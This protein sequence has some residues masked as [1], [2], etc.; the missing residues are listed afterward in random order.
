LA[1][2][3]VDRLAR[4][5]RQ[6]VTPPAGSELVVVA[7]AALAVWTIGGLPAVAAAGPRSSHLVL[8][9]ATALVAGAITVVGALGTRTLRHRRLTWLG[10]AFLLYGAVGA[11]LTVLGPAT[12]HASPGLLAAYLTAL[13]VF[14]ALL[15]ATL[16]RGPVR[17]ATGWPWLGAG[18][19]AVLAAVVGAAAA[20]W[21]VLTDLLDSPAPTGG[22][23]LGLDV[24]AATTL[25]AGHRR[26]DR[27]T[28]RV[29]AGLGVLGA[30]RTFQ[31]L[32]GLDVADADLRL[33]GLRL[34]GV[35]VVLAGV[36]GRLGEDVLRVVSQRDEHQA[37]A[38]Q[39]AS[40]AD[41]RAAELAEVRRAV[42]RAAE[43]DHELANGLAG[44]SGVAYLLDQ[45]AGGML[46]AALRAELER[47]LGLLARPT[48]DRPGRGYD[49]ARAVA[50]LALLRRA[51]GMDI[52]VETD[53]DLRVD[54]DRDAL[55]QVLANLLTNCARHAPG[56][57]VT[58]VATR[59]DPYV[60]V[61]VRDQGPGIPEG[62]E[63]LVLSR[64]YSTGGSG[65]GL[66]VSARLLDRQGGHLR[67]L[68][69]PPGR[70]GFA[71]RLEL[72][73]AR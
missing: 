66:D 33:A 36:A 67:I 69:R 51:T 60:V 58:I 15:L 50:E 47:L 35:V 59:R 32:A 57:P 29:G 34:L 6:F 18:A 19:G 49:V 11:S 46:P 17:L 13:L 30:A 38:R 4:A 48:G 27:A 65:L 40:E 2:R 31:V 16:S 12:L 54:G 9:Y 24:A 53:G 5:L 3:T 28:W 7:A 42:E 70:P 62:A 37:A 73:A 71:V 14:C 52:D 23:A 72:P 43:R 22:L 45:A 21:P 41:R 68:P 39:L 20:R 63:R 26:G 25:V 56:S 10:A 44:L 64:G 8:T 61:E 55:A 1:T